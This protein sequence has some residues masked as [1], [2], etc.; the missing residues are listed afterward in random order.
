MFISCKILIH[1]G[2]FIFLFYSPGYWVIK[3]LSLLL[4]NIVSPP[5]Q[6]WSQ[7]SKTHCLY[8]QDIKST[9]CQIMIIIEKKWQT[10]NIILIFQVVRD[11]IHSKKCVISCNLD[12]PRSYYFMWYGWY[13]HIMSCLIS[14]LVWR[15]S[16]TWKIGRYFS[17]VL[18]SVGQHLSLWPTI[19]TLSPV[20][21]KLFGGISNKFTVM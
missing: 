3:D 8:N 10:F 5:K 4:F 15:M 11:T 12:I 14:V 9:K 16:L 20:R 21:G 2:C 7:R 1:G 13:M 17:M 19:K 18:L 6:T